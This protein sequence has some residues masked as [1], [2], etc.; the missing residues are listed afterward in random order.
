MTRTVS[1]GA[2]LLL[3]HRL[4]YDDWTLPKGKA[5][6]GE[7]LEDCAVREVEEET[8]LRCMLGRELGTTSYTDRKGRPKEVEYWLMWPVEGR[9]TVP[10]REIDGARWVSVADAVEMLTYERDAA[11]VRQLGE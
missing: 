2:E 6:P 7:S 9:L 3:V 1:S 10:N 8:G 11:L 5:E 4:R